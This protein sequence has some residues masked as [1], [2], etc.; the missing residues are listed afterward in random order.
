MAV[1]QSVIF[2]GR[3]KRS[4]MGKEPK[5]KDPDSTPGLWSAFEGSD[6]TV[7]RLARDA[8]SHRYR[9]DECASGLCRFFSSGRERK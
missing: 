9:S 6:A 1:I 4:R 5:N 2:Y 8:N 3:I 7:R